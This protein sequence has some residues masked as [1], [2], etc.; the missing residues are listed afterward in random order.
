MARK[1]KK[2]SSGS[3]LKNSD[4]YLVLTCLQDEE[5]SESCQDCG[6]CDDC[7][8]ENEADCPEDC[9]TPANFRVTFSEILTP[10]EG[11]CIACT[12]SSGFAGSAKATVYTSS[13]LNGLHYL[14]QVTS[15]SWKKTFGT[16]RIDAYINSA[17]CGTLL[18]L[19][20]DPQI[21][22]YEGDIDIVLTRTSSTNY[23]LSASSN[24]VQVETTEHPGTVPKAGFRDDM[25]LR[26]FRDTTGTAYADRC[27]QSVSF[28]N[29]Y[30]SEDSDSESD[31]DEQ[32][33]MT[34]PQVTLPDDIVCDLTPTGD[35]SVDADATFAAG[36]VASAVPCRS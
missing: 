8:S 6:Y 14:P 31:P 9:C 24:M 35:T 16:A 20:E 13:S 4:G 32:L 26:L 18:S 12:D 7:S 34:T 30:T 3:L 29:D 5:D 21:T 27:D 25:Y 2:N 23:T 33:P 15:C 10:T 11:L 28:S 36:G 1:L 17:E 19:P 22:R